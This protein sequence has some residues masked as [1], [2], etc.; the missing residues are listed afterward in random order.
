MP[1]FATRV[2]GVSSGAAAGAVAALLCGCGGRSADDTWPLPNSDL[3]GTRAAAGSAIAAAHVG[4][5]GVRRPARFTATPGF[6]GIFASTP[7]ADR[8][9]AYVQD[10]TSTVFALDR[11]T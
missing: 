6:S 5:L 8:H 7:V 3:A 4:R 10:L 2:P 11:S 9:T 1:A